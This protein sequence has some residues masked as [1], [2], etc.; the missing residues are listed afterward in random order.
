MYGHVLSSL[1]SAVQWHTCAGADLE[2]IHRE[3]GV[4]IWLY[5]YIYVWLCI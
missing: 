3:G 4:S 5:V 1:C 2:I